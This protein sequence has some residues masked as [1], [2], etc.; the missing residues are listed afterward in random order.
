MQLDRGVCALSP[1]FLLPRHYTT[2]TWAWLGIS[3]LTMHA[4]SFSSL[5]VSGRNAC[6]LLADNDQYLHTF[7]ISIAC[8]HT[9]MVIRLRYLGLS[10]PSR[11]VYSTVNSERSRFTRFTHRSLGCICSH[12]VCIIDCVGLGLVYLGWVFCPRSIS[13][14]GLRSALWNVR[15]SNETCWVWTRWCDE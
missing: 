3:L 14:A 5:F 15:S 9:H 10:C 7:F 8:M 11:R 2:T 13:A 12:G 6:L 4:L 1:S